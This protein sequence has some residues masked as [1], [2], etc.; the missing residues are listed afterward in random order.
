MKIRIGFVTNSSSSS[1]VIV[2]KTKKTRSMVDFV[3]ENMNLIMQIVKS[4]DLEDEINNKESEEA[5][6]VKEKIIEDT[7]E[8]DRT[9]KPGR[10]TAFTVGTEGD[11]IIQAILYCMSD[12]KSKSFDWYTGDD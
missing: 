6:T 4:H 12:G 5:R 8:Y 9:F 10:P 7:M 11:S 1:F 2:N 3:N